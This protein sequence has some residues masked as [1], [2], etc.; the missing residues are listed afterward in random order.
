M[1]S[2]EDLIWA[3]GF[4]DGEG[5][6]CIQRQMRGKHNKTYH[7]LDISVFQNDRS[8]VELLMGMF[9]GRIAA[10]DRGWKWRAC[11]PTAGVALQELMPFL[12]VKRSQAEI[13][14]RF[15]DRRIP[16]G[17]NRPA[18]WSGDQDEEDYMNVKQLKRV[19]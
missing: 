18:D 6:V 10:E 14:V 3:A 1:A 17:Q 8:A 7:Y 19:I 4:F 11:G 2:Q 12:R 15:Q 9:G 13:A 5:C 16:P